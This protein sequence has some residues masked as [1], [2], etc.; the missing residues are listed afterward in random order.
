MDREVVAAADPRHEGAVSI[1]RPEVSDR[2]ALHDR[3]AGLA[4]GR[5]ENGFGVANV[6]A[7][8][9]LHED[10]CRTAFVVAV[11]RHPRAR[12]LDWLAD[13]RADTTWQKLVD[14]GAVGHRSS[15][16]AVGDFIHFSP[17]QAF[18]LPPT[19][20]LVP[21]LDPV[22][23]G[24]QRRGRELLVLLVLAS[25]L[26]AHPRALTDRLRRRLVAVDFE[27]MLLALR[28]RPDPPGRE[29]LE[30]VAIFDE[31]LDLVGR[32][33]VGRAAELERPLL[34]VGQMVGGGLRHGCFSKVNQRNAL[35]PRKRTELLPKSWD[36]S[37]SRET[38]DVGPSEVSRL[39]LR[40]HSWT[41]RDCPLASHSN[42]I[43]V[44]LAISL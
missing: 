8:A 24:C 15:G 22:I 38:S 13:E 42:G 6:I 40:I 3:V 5:L 34:Q 39:R 35:I 21:L 33:N 26:Q 41:R 18:A 14:V 23:L 32:E 1:D 44:R 43:A 9:Q 20:V 25:P 2:P 17:P 29:G 4:R 19:P 16:D 7:D 12:W 37:R 27:E 30:P 36:R 31:G 10:R 11:D 28:C